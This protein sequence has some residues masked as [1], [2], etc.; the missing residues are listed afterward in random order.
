MRRRERTSKAGAE[1]D[2]EVGPSP[3]QVPGH[4]DEDA[5]ASAVADRLALDPAV[6]F[7]GSESECERREG[8]ERGAQASSGGRDAPFLPAR[9]RYRG[10]S[11]G[12]SRDR[13]G[14][15]ETNT[16]TPRTDS[17]RRMSA[18]WTSMGLSVRIEP[19][20]SVRAGGSGQLGAPL[21]EDRSMHATDRNVDLA[22]PR[23]SGAGNRVADLVR[24]V[25]VGDK[26]ENSR[27]D[28]ARFCTRSRVRQLL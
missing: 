17:R 2:G 8:E 28:L 14:I 4:V 24:L 22:L 26:G 11:P 25:E 9:Q 19:S 7:C 13:V 23:L 12:W 20:G 1:D 3:R 5:V 27:L 16:S 15:V 6:G 18:W 10:F 21:G